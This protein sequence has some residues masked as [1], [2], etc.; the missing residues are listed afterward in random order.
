[1]G[2]R[3]AAAID[4][5]PSTRAAFGNEAA[6]KRDDHIPVTFSVFRLYL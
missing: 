6:A 3:S 1:L 4:G 5:D 2:I